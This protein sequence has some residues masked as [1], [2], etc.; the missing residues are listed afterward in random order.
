VQVSF[1]FF[2]L[3]PATEDG[4]WDLDGTAR[5][6]RRE[7]NGGRKCWICQSHAGVR[8]FPADLPR[9]LGFPVGSGEV[10][11]V[12]SRIR[13]KSGLDRFGLDRSTADGLV[14]GVGF[15]GCYGLELTGFFCFDCLRYYIFWLIAEKEV[16][17]CGWGLVSLGVEEKQ[18]KTMA[19]WCGWM[20]VTG[21]DFRWIFPDSGR[22]RSFEPLTAGQKIIIIIITILKK[23]KKITGSRRFFPKPSVIADGLAQTV[24]KFI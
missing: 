14:I 9:L 17:G 21:A 12:S 1:F 4:Q 7:R 23:T 5:S 6:G 2:S 8:G 16:V 20:V 10:A 3:R 24:Q 15:G 18:R 22:E 19:I 11:G 13:P